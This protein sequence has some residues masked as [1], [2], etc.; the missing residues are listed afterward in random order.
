MLA[1]LDLHGY[2]KNRFNGRTSSHG[3]GENHG[4]DHQQYYISNSSEPASPF[5]FGS[6]HVDPENAADPGLSGDLNYPLFSVI[7]DKNR[8]KTNVTYKRTAKNIGS[9]PSTYAVQVK[10]LLEFQ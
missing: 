7:F 1:V 5:A 3:Q 2:N 6:G 8:K 4:L 9:I 10:D